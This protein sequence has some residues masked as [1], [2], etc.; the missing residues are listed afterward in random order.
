MI[1]DS[2]AIV[3]I[4]YD[5]PEALDFLSLIDSDPSPMMSSVTAL[6][7]SIVLQGR[8][9]NGSIL[10]ELDRFYQE[11]NIFIVP[12]TREHYLV[13]RMAYDLYGKGRHKAKLNFGDCASYALAKS[14]NVPLLY[15]G[16]DFIRT[17]IKSVNP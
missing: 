14:Y 2:S 12:F 10:S 9:G 11:M 7:T 13:G 5:E 3:A 15:K 17:D 1:I 4:F 6:E 16:N 8:K